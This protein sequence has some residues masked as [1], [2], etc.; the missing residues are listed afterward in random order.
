M[1][2]ML[3]IISLGLNAVLFAGAAAFVRRKGGWRF[4]KSKL[5]ARGVVKDAALEV[6]EDA[7]WRN[8]VELFE[9]FGV[10]REDTVF[11]GDSLTDL[12]AWS[13]LFG[14]ARLKN[15]GISGDTT[16]GVLKRLDGL[17][18]GKPRKVFLMIG[19]NDINNGVP[20][21][22]IAGNYRAIVAR[23]REGSPE[24]TI[25]LQSVLPL[26]SFRWGVAAAERILAFNAQIAGL[27]DGGRVRYLDLHARF[28]EEGRLAPACSYDGLHLNG[29]GYARWKAAIA[30]YVG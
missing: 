25:Y 20:M 28:A 27:D 3:T 13:E 16:A 26:D 5:A 11:L 10:T 2:T 7:Y 9:T 6:L 1:T 19:I 17:V 14:D 30:E 12:C 23:L 29:E 15:R 8:K 21:E 24:T 18:A 4:L 22:A